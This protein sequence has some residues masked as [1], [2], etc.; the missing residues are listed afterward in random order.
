MALKISS[1]RSQGNVDRSKS[2]RPS[3]NFSSCVRL[4]REIVRCQV[5]LSW[6]LSAG[7][8]KGRKQAPRIQQLRTCM[9]G[10]QYRRKTNPESALLQHPSGCGPAACSFPTRHCLLSFSQHPLSPLLLTFHG[11]PRGS[12]L[13]RECFSKARTFKGL[14]SIY[15]WFCMHGNPCRMQAYKNFEAHILN[16]T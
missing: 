5:S 14:Y 13:P 10:R 6:R 2:E 12:S 16:T 8:H 15:R 7:Y 9:T 4:P 11:L 3:S 1:R